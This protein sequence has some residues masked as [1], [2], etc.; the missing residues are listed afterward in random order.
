MSEETEPLKRVGQAVFTRRLEVGFETQQELA[1]AAGVALSTAALL[2]RGKTFPRPSKRV[3]I[4]D[5]LQWPRGALDALR[6]NVPLPQA[7]TTPNASTAATAALPRQS[8]A[9]SPRTYLVIAKGLTDVAATCAL[10][11]LQSAQRP[12]S[13]MALQELDTQL[14]NLETLIS[15]TLPHAGDAFDETMSA[16]T[17]LHEQRIAIRQ[18]AANDQR[19]ATL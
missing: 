16:I 12:E 18:A 14:F 1:D 6:R 8:P 19:L 15:A 17:A 13:R 2:E 10:V 7:D 5:A 9:V 4:E 3:L 11:L